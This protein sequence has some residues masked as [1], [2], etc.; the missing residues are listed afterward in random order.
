MWRSS[1]LEAF[2]EKLMK[3]VLTN[4]IELKHYQAFFKYNS[5]RKF[6]NLMRLLVEYKQRKIRLT[7]FPPVLVIESTNVCN[8]RC[9][10]CPTGAGTLK[11]RPRMLKFEEFKK[12]VD[13]IGDYLYQ[14]YFHWNG[15]PLLNKELWQ[16]VEYAHK[17]RIGA[18]FDT[19]LNLLNKEEA[20]KLVLSGLDYLIMS[21]D[22]LSQETYVNYRVGGDFEKVIE[23]IKH[24]VYW[25]RK[26]RM[27]TPLIIWQFL[28]FK[29][30]LH[31]VDK[32]E[33]F[34]KHLGVDDV[35]IGSA[36]GE[37]NHPDIYMRVV[38]VDRSKL[39]LEGEEWLKY[40][41][42][43]KTCDFLW[44]CAYV[45][46]DG[47]LLPC[48]LVYSEGTEFGNVFE[49]DKPFQEIWNNAKFQAAR[50]IFRYRKFPSN[51][52][53]ICRNC[54]LAKSYVFTK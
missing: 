28:V 43:W 27:T 52:D 12:V 22:G 37:E 7:S 53:I 24:I 10:L 5:P 3:R 23:N 48:C 30:N 2:N 49:E 36:V 13:S 21:I 29:H 38:N 1:L 20:K 15:E 6:F 18:A 47:A 34:A 25:K 16:M 41:K 42:K 39:I 8:L 45:A 46:V 54:F 32:V 44:F 19:N 9:P 35:S 31:E 50:S 26:L 51:I 14:I 40:A 33:D 17:K 11:R 4:R